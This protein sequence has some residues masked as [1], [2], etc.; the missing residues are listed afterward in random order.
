MTQ[1]IPP[2][3]LD[4]AYVLLSDLIAGRWAEAHRE[5]DARLREQVRPDAFARAWAKAVESVGGFERM[6]A[7]S[8]RRLGGYTVV[9]IPLTFAA[10]RALGEVVVDNA[11]Q[12]AG[13]ALQFPHPRPPDPEPGKRRGGLVVR[14]PEVA[15]L[16]R[17]RL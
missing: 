13:L 15:A 10:G 5:L 4:R 9:D 14:N 8:A 1:D 16:M 11:G 6:D 12:V 17:T 2:D 7:P 3:A